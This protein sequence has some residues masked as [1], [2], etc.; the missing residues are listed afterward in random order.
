MIVSVRSS[1]PESGSRGFPWPVLESGNGS[2]PDGAYSVHLTHREQGRSFDL[3]HHVEGASL[4]EAWIREG[5]TRFVCSVASPVSA[6]REVAV[7]SEASHCVAWR[8][9]DLGSYPLFTPMIVCAEDIDYRIDWERDG[10]NPM[11]DRVDLHLAKGSRLAVCHT[12]ALQSG[13]V[14]LLDLGK[15]AGLGSGQFYIKDS[16]EN[17]FRFKVKLAPDLHRHLRERINQQ[18]AGGANVMTHIVSAALACLQRNYADDDGEEGW[19]SYPNLVS[20]AHQLEEKRQPGWWEDDF[21]PE[22]V[23]TVLHPHKIAEKD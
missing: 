7:S 14:G 10:V 6:Y 17:G 21:R 1:D 23:A 12:F 4:I 15:D 18:D 13:L 19:R 20:L 22:K 11:W 8:P 3:R 9:D 2:F 16:T 5:K